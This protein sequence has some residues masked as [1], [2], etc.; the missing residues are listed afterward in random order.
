MLIDYHVHTEFSDDSEY[1]ME[2]VIKDAIS[3]GLDEIC[4]TD[5]VD[6]GI[7]RD[8]NDPRGIIYRKGGLGEPEEMPLAN[9]H[10]DT[11]FET[12]KNLRNIYG[13]HISLKLGLE[14]GMQ[15]HTIPQYEKLFQSY[16]LDFI[17]LSVHEINDKEFWTQDFQAGRSHNHRRQRNMAV[18][19]DT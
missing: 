2:D 18:C 7:K 9:V 11:Y 3:L 4:F 8:W 17:I 6:Y 10:Y 16:P 13:S 5:H 19:A 14:F 1:R 15:M 12:F